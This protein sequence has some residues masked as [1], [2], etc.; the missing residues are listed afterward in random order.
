MSDTCFCCQCIA[1]QLDT[2]PM[3]SRGGV[4]RKI[5]AALT[6]EKLSQLSSEIRHRML[7]VLSLGYA[8][9][10]EK[11]IL[12]KILMADL[13]TKIPA[14]ELHEVEYQQGMVMKG[15]QNFVE[16]VKSQLDLL[17]S[18]PTGRELFK[19]L[20]RSGKKVTIIPA[21]RT[22]E[23]RPDNYRAASAPGKVLEWR[24]ETG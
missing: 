21:S 20:A 18:L 15:A 24:D 19:S 10:E 16:Q 13:I 6:I 1:Q 7:D 12:D 3:R 11:D 9:R 14:T 22:N 5:V 8:P 4:V 17:T 2:A 23:A